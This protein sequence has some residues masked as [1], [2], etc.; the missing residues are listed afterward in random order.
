MYSLNKRALKLIFVL[1][2]FLFSTLL[3][4]T[5]SANIQQT[6]FH[7]KAIDFDPTTASP[8]FEHWYPI[9]K[10]NAYD[11]DA[12][13]FFGP[14]KL[15][16]FEEARR[17]HNLLIDRSLQKEILSG[18]NYN[19]VVQRCTEYVESHNSFIKEQG[20]CNIT[21]GET[22]YGTINTIAGEFLDPPNGSRPTTIQESLIGLNY[23]FPYGFT[24]QKIYWQ[25]A[26]CTHPG[27]G[28]SAPL[29]VYPLPFIITYDANEEKDC[30]DGCPQDNGVDAFSGQI[31]NSIPALVQKESTSYS[32]GV[33]HTLQDY[34]P[35]DFTY[36]TN[37]TTETENIT[38]VSGQ[39]VNQLDIRMNTGF[40]SPYKDEN[41]QAVNF[42]KGVSNIQIWRKGKLSSSFGYYDY[43]INNP[44]WVSRIGKPQ[45]KLTGGQQLNTESSD[46]ILSKANLDKE[47]FS[48]GQLTKIKKAD[49]TVVKINYLSK[50]TS[51]FSVSKGP[52]PSVQG[53]ITTI[54]DDTGYFYDVTLGNSLFRH[55]FDNNKRLL[56]IE[57]LKIKRVST[58]ELITIM[59][60]S[61]I[62]AC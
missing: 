7:C 2:S 32:S 42:L 13:G 1:V 20:T 12:S 9:A 47:Y 44:Q 26:A 45:E 60:M 28:T 48:K 49:G 59:M 58:Q 43:D 35:L 37:T 50:V 15:T 61:V 38:E 27:Y 22:Y 16:S 24:Y 17:Y 6:I 31:N 11:D 14:G 34:F 46:F 8:E 18:Q 51:T 57:N 21:L 30:D 39:W 53:S 4:A 23:I 41:W 52:V 33:F 62:Q 19:D 40:V 36:S 55:R 10:I 54:Y 25:R 5:P 3:Y 29:Y 56:Y